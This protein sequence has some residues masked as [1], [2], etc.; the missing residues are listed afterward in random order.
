MVPW[1]DRDIWAVVE[2]P[3]GYVRQIVY[4]H[5]ADREAAEQKAARHGVPAVQE[6]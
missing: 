4:R 1:G 3:G 2:N 6:E 5:E